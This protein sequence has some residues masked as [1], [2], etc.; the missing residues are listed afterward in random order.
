MEEKMVERLKKLIFTSW[1]KSKFYRKGLISP[2]EVHLEHPKEE[3]HGDWATNIAL[4]LAKKVKKPSREIAQEL[5]SALPKMDLVEKIDM[6]GPG[7]INFWLAK[8]PLLEVIIETIKAKEN[9]GQG[10]NLAGKKIMVEY[11]DPNTHKAFH[12]G[13]LRNISLGESVVCLLE[14]EG[15]KVV[16]TSYQ[17]DVG[18]HI[19]KCIYG[20][21]HNSS[22][23]SQ[24]T[25]LKDKRERVNLIAQAYTEGS[26]T[27]EE[28]ENGKKEIALIN[29]QIY[30]R[31]PGIW[32]LYKTTRQWSLDYFEEIYKRL[33]IHYDKQYFESEVYESGKENVLKGLRKG[34]FVESEGA[35]IFPGEK[36]GL[37]NRVFITSEGNPT[38]EGKDMG[39][40]PLQYKE[41]GG[42]LVIRVVGP[43]QAGYFQ[44]VFEAQSQLFPELRGKFVHLPNGWVRLK[45]GKMS[46]RLG[47]VVLGE[48]LI[49]EVKR[50]L[51][52]KI[53][54]ME[55][56]VAESVGVG[57]VKYSFLKFSTS[58]EVAFD[59][60]E[61]INLEGNS[62]PYLQYTYARCRSVL[63]KANVKD[64]PLRWQRRILINP[65]EEAILR[66]LYKFPEVVSDS[67]KSYAPNF[68]C[69]YLYDLAQKYNTFYNKHSILTPKEKREE[70]RDFRLALTAAT[71][72][73]LKNGLTLLGIK[74]P[75]RM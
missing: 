52:R 2:D 51:K 40:G 48:W 45:K 3:G 28:D 24:I 27:F 38:Y 5:I 44:V 33:G 11:G 57:A 25:I 50:R 12:I 61:S 19:A 74:S 62:G 56:E 29:K 73:I 46:S 68:L 54:E 65:E 60:D 10:K 37:H 69:E 15:A 75:E 13:H 72:Q 41:S 49:D 43:E 1:G 53:G 22:L 4:I 26:K 58:S 30:A 18:M 20:F 14:A 31:D 23:L 42:D 47:N 7:F 34:T 64:T 36:F 9:F 35:V 39:L 63:R 70:V 71:G 8:K 21:L 32:D 67:A 55:E 6:A 66:T 16:H 59:I 17:G